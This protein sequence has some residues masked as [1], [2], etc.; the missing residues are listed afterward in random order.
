VDL[1]EKMRRRKR[2]SKK[3]LIKKSGDR[4]SSE[5]DTGMM[6]RRTKKMRARLRYSR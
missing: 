3:R 2:D 5:K 4:A 1:I 6:E